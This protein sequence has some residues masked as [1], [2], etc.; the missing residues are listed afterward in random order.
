MRHSL[1]TKQINVL[2]NWSLD[3]DRSMMQSVFIK[4]HSTYMC[5]CVCVCVG[6]GVGVCVGVCGC[7]CGCV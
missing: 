2:I 7:V 4:T 1:W 5:V 6:V 3:A